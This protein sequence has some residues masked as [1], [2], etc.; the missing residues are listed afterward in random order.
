MSTTDETAQQALP[1]IPEA[2][3]FQRDLYLYW[4]CVGAASGLALTSKLYVSRPG[5]RRV[6]VRLAAADGALAPTQDVPEVDDVRLLY[7]RRLLERLGL[8]QMN[9][10]RLVAAKRDA[11]ARFLAQPVGERLRLCVRVWVAGG[12]WPDHPD[13]RMPPPRLL[14][15]A[16]PRLAL[17]RRR[18]A[19]LLSER[20]PGDLA[21]IPP[22]APIPRAAA[23][24]RRPRAAA[25][26][27]HTAA[28][29]Q[30]VPDA[31]IVRA[32]L[33][34]PL[35]WMGLVEVDASGERYTI[36]PACAALRAPGRADDELRETPGRILVQPNFSIVAYPPLTA[37]ALLLLHTCA[38]EAA[39]ERIARFTLT[40]VA[41]TR[42]R[43]EGWTAGDV[44]M[45]LA[46]LS[47][48]SLPGNIRTTLDDW[49]R[50]VERLRLTESVIVIEAR[51][52]TVLDKLLA[53]RAASDWISRRLTD[54]AALIVPGQGAAVRN[55]LLR[56]GELPAVRQSSAG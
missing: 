52:S 8:L 34:G 42:A 29:A 33:L 7:L 35:A 15:P 19:E 3:R 12:W 56:H 9:E 17:G 11:M 14:V 4:Q 44:A 48:G 18:L 38:D 6:R 45:R 47:G 53:E 36:T 2:V 5:L 27:A 49:E 16:L 22:E 46:S 21:V 31:P 43:G 50:H 23:S 51:E 24:G 1:G 55:W 39:I 37:P 32:A 41:L 30:D 10:G 26:A 25:H 28:D 40:R 20:A 13:P 54:T